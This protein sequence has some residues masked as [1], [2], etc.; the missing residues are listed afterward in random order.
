MSNK[1]KQA[2]AEAEAQAQEARSAAMALLGLTEKGLATG[3]DSDAHDAFESKKGIIEKCDEIAKLSTK[4]K[5]FGAPIRITI[6]SGGDVTVEP[7]RKVSFPKSVTNRGDGA[8]R[9][10]QCM[11]DGVKYDTMS[12]ACDHFNLSHEGISARVVLERAKRK[13]TITAF[14]LV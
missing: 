2:N 3:K 7:T 6:E 8:A 4:V 10:T 12:A 5:A 9:G 1:D 11:V 13:G 14:E